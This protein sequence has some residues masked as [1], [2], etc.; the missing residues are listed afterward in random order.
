VIRYAVVTGTPALYNESPFSNL[1]LM[2]TWFR[3]FDE[4]TFSQLQQI[5][6]APGPRAE[7]IQRAAT[8]GPRPDLS[9]RYMEQVRGPYE[10]PLPETLGLAWGNIQLN[11]RQYLVNHAVLAPL[12]IWAGHTPVR[13]ADAPHLP[14]S[15][16]YAIWA[17]EF[18]LL[19]LALW[20]TVRALRDPETF[21][22]S[23]SFLCVVLFLTA[24]HVVIAVDERFTT[25][26]LPLVGLFAGARIASLSRARQRVVVGYA[27]SAQ[28]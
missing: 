3:V 25:P 23:V 2:G 10:R 28:R 20:Q 19:L 14:S 22:L 24:V 27:H 13:Q 8:I 11:V 12:L 21:G 18:L 16:R 7:A 15:A 4:Q 26:A 5:E 17:A 6:S 9:Q 1:L